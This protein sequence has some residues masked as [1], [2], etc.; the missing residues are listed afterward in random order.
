MTQN[1]FKITYGPRLLESK[2][3]LMPLVNVISMYQINGLYGSASIYDTN[4]RFCIYSLIELNSFSCLRNR[5]Q[6][7]NLRPVP[8]YITAGWRTKLSPGIWE[9]WKHGAMTEGEDAFHHGLLPSPSL[10]SMCTVMQNKKLK[11]GTNQ[12]SVLVFYGIMYS[13]MCENMQVMKIQ[14]FSREL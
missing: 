9:H 7:L 13:C 8:K 3:C 2:L 12:L 14:L 1:V 5:A 10:C 6:L 11:L 4:K